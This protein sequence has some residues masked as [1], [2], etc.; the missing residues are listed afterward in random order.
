M[1]V[2]G[3]I[4]T[5]NMIYLRQGLTMAAY[6]VARSVSSHGGVQAD[7]VTRGHQVLTARRIAG[8]SITVTP[9]VDSTTAPGTRIDVTVTA[10]ADANASGPQWF[11]QGFSLSK[12]VTMSR[13]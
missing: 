6:E 2:F 13:M 1:L 4:E 5:A 7:A 12:T 10:G 8:A 3:A 11:Y 9:T